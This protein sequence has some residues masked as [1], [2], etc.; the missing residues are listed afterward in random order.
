M[1]PYPPRDVVTVAQLRDFD[2]LIDV[3]S[4]SEFN[5]DHIPGAISCPVLNDEERAHVGTVYK[6]V[7]SFEAKR[8]GAALI[9]RNIAHHIETRFIQKKKNWRPLVYCWRGGKRSE[10]LMH[11]LKQIGW[12]AA[13]LEGGYKSYRAAVITALE[14][15]PPHLG[16]RVICGPTGSGKSRLLQAL[17]GLG[18]QVLDL[19]KLAAHRGSV[20]GALPDEPQPT[21]KMFESRAWQQLQR[22]DPKRPVYVEAESKKIGNVR[23]PDTLLAAMWSSA[24]IRL[25]ADT[26]LR[27]LLLKEEYLHFLQDPAVLH[28]KLE[29]LA[30]RYG[31]ETLSRWK[32]YSSNG[33]WDTLVVELIEQHYDPA[34]GKSTARHYAHYQDALIVPITSP[35]DGELQ[36]AAQTILTTENV[37]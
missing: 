34:Y 15:L 21:Q 8:I 19:E 28:Q 6:Q 35:D 24:C 26:A 7:S 22:F 12:D 11:V 30:A 36:R 20:L 29:I 27:T 33:L 5:E 31:H 32:Q 14:E 37:K 9:A 16:F 18:A 25:E 4:P 2:E 10:A 1:H 23:V 17:S 3:R 13:R